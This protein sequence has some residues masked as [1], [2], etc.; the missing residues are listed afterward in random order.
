MGANHNSIKIIGTETDNYAQGYFVYD[1][2]KSGTVTVSHL[3]FGPQP[4]HMPFLISSANFI[5]CHQFNFLER[6]DVLEK[7]APGA[8]FLL[9]SPFGPDDVWD[10]LPREVQQSIID[11]HLKLYVIDAYQVARETGMG[12]RINTIMQ[13]CFFDISGV[14][15]QGEAIPAIKNS[16]RNTYL[17]KGEAVVQQNFAAVDYTLEHLYTVKVPAQVSGAVTRPP[18]VSP[19]A[20][21]FV[22]GLTAMLMAGKG[23]SVPVSMMPADGTYPTGTSQ[24]EKRSIAQEIPAWDEAVCIQCGKCALV[25][26]HAAIRM[27]FYP[28]ELAAGAPETF[29]THKAIGKE[30]PDMLCTIQVAPDDCTG[31]GACV[32]ICPAKNKREP[33]FKAINMAPQLPLREAERVNYEFFLDL[34]E[35]DR[36]LVKI[37]SVKGS[38]L[39]QPLFDYSG[40]CAGCGEPPHLNLLSQMLGDHKVIARGAGGS[41]R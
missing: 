22:Q 19:A 1:S 33:R 39:L 12:V 29:K 15:P 27:K 41:T 36:D 8:T 16:I 25:C 17:K 14:L 28:Q 26:P 7:A 20:P 24:W 21:A 2:K 40:A 35:I 6:Y 34:P 5:A 37:A 32:Y 30:F 38:Q 31:C 13:T 3:R 23:D 9:N 11:K 10:N 18:A 4:I